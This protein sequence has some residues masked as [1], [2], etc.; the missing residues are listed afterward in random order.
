M[1]QELLKHYLLAL[2]AEGH[3]R[4]NDRPTAIFAKVTE[5]M[6]EDFPAVVKDLANMAV[7]HGVRTVGNMA[8]ERV[9][10]KLDQVAADIGRRGIG[11]V[12][13]DMQ[14]A[15]ARGADAKAGR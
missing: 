12:W 8:S 2:I 13:R 5:L 4:A 9:R 10:Q 15:Y 6:R 14:A 7:E 1:R 11:A 3:F